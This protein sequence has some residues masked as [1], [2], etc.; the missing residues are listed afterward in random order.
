[1]NTIIFNMTL[2]PSGFIFIFINLRRPLGG[3]W[4]FITK[5]TAMPRPATRMTHTQSGVCSRRWRHRHRLHCRSGSGCRRGSGSGRRSIVD[6]WWGNEASRT[7]SDE[8]SVAS[9]GGLGLDCGGGFGLG[10][11]GWVFWGGGGEGFMV[12]GQ[13]GFDWVIWEI[14]NKKLKI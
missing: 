5:L 9:V 14:Q 10:R 6:H 1:M 13:T 8:V 11:M 2:K 4:K 3:A 12:L 7:D